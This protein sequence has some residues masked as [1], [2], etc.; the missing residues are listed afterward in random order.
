MINSPEIQ[1]GSNENNQLFFDWCDEKT[2]LH[3]LEKP[4]FFVN[5]REIWLTKMGKNIGFEENGKGEFK[6]P[7]LVIK[8]VGNLFF[9]VAL[10]SQGKNRHKFYHK[11]ESAIFNENHQ[12]HADSSYAILSQVR[13]MD[14]RRFIEKMGRISSEE[15]REIKQKLRA[16]LL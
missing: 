15:F 8:K 9:T 4:E 10:T 13:V 6:R 16:T 14:K 7:V 5:S 1:V 11:F 3:S 12:N 2:E